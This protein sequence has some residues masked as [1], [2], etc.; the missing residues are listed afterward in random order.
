LSIQNQKAFIVREA[1]ETDAK[2]IVNYLYENQDHFLY[3]ISKTE[4]MKLDLTYEKKMIRLH[5]ER[6]NC[7]FYLALKKD[8][9]LGMLNFVGGNRSRDMHDGEFGLSVHKDCFGQGIGTVLM[10][11]LMRWGRRNQVIKRMTLFVMHSNKRA[12]NLYQRFGFRIEGVRRKAVRFEDGRI[13][14]LVMM[15]ILKEEGSDEWIGDKQ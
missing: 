5:A 11:N 14:D 7:I 13:Q 1:K 2:A 4:E 6:E 12:I 8:K 3:M 10:E 9:V 15:G